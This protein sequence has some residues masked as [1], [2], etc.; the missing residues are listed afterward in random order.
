MPL[1]LTTLA[2]GLF[3]RTKLNENFQA[4]EDYINDRALFRD[5]ESGDTNSM[6]TNLDMNS[7]RIINLPDGVG[8]TEPATVGQVQEVIG[9]VNELGPN[10][11]QGG[12]GAV[13]RT[14]LSRLQD[15]ASVK[16]FGAVGDGTTDDGDAINTALTWW[17]EAAG[18]TLYSQKGITC[19]VVPPLLPYPLVIKSS[20]QSTWTV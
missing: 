12:T 17:A 2:S 15:I 5:P 11:N 4:T 3:S 14:V 9:Q 10:Y 8:V 20:T 6:Q 19:M 18:R 1:N 16:D 13:T 7:N